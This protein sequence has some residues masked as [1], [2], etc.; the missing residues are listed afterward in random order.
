M[1]ELHTTYWGRPRC[2][3]RYDSTTRQTAKDAKS[4][5]TEPENCTS[6]IN[7]V[8]SLAAI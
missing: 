8:L 2:L 4:A 7:P 5:K 3:P 1:S 6:C